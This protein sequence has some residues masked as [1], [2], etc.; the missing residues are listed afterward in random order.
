[1]DYLY[2]VATNKDVLVTIRVAE[3]VRD[4]FKTAA[5]LKGATMSGLMHQFIIRTIREEKEQEPKAFQPR[6]AAARKASIKIGGD[7][8]LDVEKPVRAKRTA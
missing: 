7:G 8:E 2:N 6:K 3:T 4:E 5:E 1:M